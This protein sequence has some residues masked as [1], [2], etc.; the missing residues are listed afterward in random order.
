MK[1]D[2]RISRNIRA[3][4]FFNNINTTIHYC[5][6]T[7]LDESDNEL[8]VISVVTEEEDA[9]DEDLF[10]SECEE[11]QSF[12]FRLLPTT[13]LNFVAKR[14]RLVYVLDF[15][16]SSS[17]VD[18]KTGEVLSDKMYPCLHRCLSGLVK[19]FLLPGTNL[20][21]QTELYITVIAYTPVLACTVNQV[22]SQGYHL[23]EENLEGFLSVIKDKLRAFEL[24]LAS[25]TGSYNRNS[26]GSEN[27]HSIVT[28]DDE[29]QDSEET[30]PPSMCKANDSSNISEAGIINLLRQGLFAVQLLPENSSAGIVVISDGVLGVTDHTQ[31]DVIL[32]QLRSSTISCSF[33]KIGQSYCPRSQFG[34]V[35]HLELLQF[36]A[37]ATF[38]AYFDSCPDVTTNIESAH[39]NVYQKALLMW[40]FQKGLE[41][42]KYGLSRHRYLEP[43]HPANVSQRI[44]SHPIK[45]SLSMNTVIRRKHREM[46]LQTH[47]S[48]VLAVRLREGYTIK[49]ITF[50]KGNS[51]IEVQL[52]LPWREF[53][54]IEYSVKAE[55]PVDPNKRL[56]LVEIMLEGSY[57]F[58]H[59]MFS[60]ECSIKQRRWRS[61]RFNNVRKFHLTLQTLC[62]TDQLLVHLQSFDTNPV[63]HMLSDSI[64]NGLSVFY[65]TANSVTPMINTQHNTKDSMF[66]QFT[67]FWK[68]VVNLDIKIWQKWM[69]SH[70]IGVV[71][72]HDTPLPKYLHVPNASGRFS[73]VT[74]RQALTSLHGL[75]QKWS[76][77]V[78]I[79][80]SS[81]IKFL[82][83]DAEK[84]PSRFLLLRLTSKPPCMVIRA[85]FLGGTPGGMRHKTIKDLKRKV[86]ALKF[87]QRGAQKVDRT[88]KSPKD[89]AKDKKATP[90]PPLLR[91]WSEI[92]CCVL[93]TKP[94]EH[95][96]IS[97]ER[98]PRD[99]TV[100]EDPSKYIPAHMTSQQMNNKVT[101]ANAF[102]TLSRYLH[103]Q[104]WIWTVKQGKVD[105]TMQAV[106]RILSTLTKLNKITGGFHFASSN[107]GIV[108]MVLE[109]DMMHKTDGEK[110][111][112]VGDLSRCV[113]QYIM[114][115][116][117][118]KTTRE[119]TS[120][121]DLDEY[122]TT[123]ADGELQL[124][125]ECWIEPQYGVSTNN[126]PE[127]RQWNGLDYKGIARTFYPKDL[128]CLSS[129]V[130][131]DHL[132]YVCQNKIVFSDLPWKSDG[133]YVS[134]DIDS[135]SPYRD[136]VQ[137][138]S[139]FPANIHS[140]GFPFDLLSLLPKSQ[141][142]ELLFSSFALPEENS[143]DTYRDIKGSNSLLIELLHQKLMES[144]EREISL[145]HTECKV[146]L[147]LLKNRERDTFE[148]PFPFPM[149]HHI[150]ED[151][152]V[153]ESENQDE[154]DS[155]KQTTAAGVKSTS[156]A[157][158]SGVHGLSE[159]EEKVPLWKCFVRS[160]NNTHLYLTLLPASFDDLLLLRNVEL[161]SRRSESP[162]RRSESEPRDISAGKR[163]ETKSES[164]VKQEVAE[165]ESSTSDHADAA[166]KNADDQVMAVP[167][168]DEIDGNK[169][170]H[171]AGTESD[172]FCESSKDESNEVENPPSTTERSP[173]HV[174]PVYVYECYFNNIIDALVNP[175]GFKLPSDFHEDL[176][177][178][179][180]EN[181]DTYL[182]RSPM[183][184]RISFESERQTSFD[185][186]D[187]LSTPAHFM[188]LAQDRRMTE[189]SDGVGD[190]KQQ[191]TILTEAYYSCFVHG[192]FQS[193]QQGY[194]IDKHD[195][196]AAINNICTE[197]LPIETEITT[198]LHASCGHFQQMVESVRDT[199]Q[200]KEVTA[201]ETSPVESPRKLSVRFSDLID[202]EEEEG[203][204]YSVPSVLRLP[205][206]THSLKVDSMQPCEP[207]V[208]LQKLIKNK[209]MDIAQRWF[210]VVPSD[211][212]FYFYCP[213]SVPVR[214]RQEG[215]VDESTI[216]Q[217]P[218]FNF[219]EPK[220]EFPDKKSNNPDIASIASQLDSQESFNDSEYDLCEDLLQTKD[221]EMTPLFLHFTCTI[222]DRSENENVSITKLVPCLGELM[223]SIDRVLDLNLG[224]MKITFDIN[225]LTY[226]TDDEEDT[227]L[228]R[229][230]A[231]HRSISD[232][233]GVSDTSQG[234]L[235]PPQERDVD[236]S[237]DPGPLTK[238]MADP[239]AHLP[240]QQHDSVVKFKE[241][242]EWL[243]RDEIA[244]S[245]LHM[246]P[247][248]TD[249]LQ[250]VIE[251]IRQSSSRG[252]PTCSHEKIPL[253]FVYGAEHSL[254]KFNEEFERLHLHGYRLVQEENFYYCVR[255]KAHNNLSL[256]ACALNS[257]LVELS[258]EGTPALQGSLSL[259][260]LNQEDSLMS[261]EAGV[262]RTYV[263]P[264]F[265]SPE[266]AKFLR[267]SAV[268][269]SSDMSEGSTH[270]LFPKC[271]EEQ[272]PVAVDGKKP[273]ADQNVEGQGKTA[274]SRRSS[275]ESSGGSGRIVAVEF[276]QNLN[277]SKV[278]QTAVTSPGSNTN[279]EGNTSNQ[280]VKSHQVETT[281]LGDSLEELWLKKSSSFSGFQNDQSPE[282]IKRQESLAALPPLPPVRQT[283]Q[284][285]SLGRLRH[286]SA[287]S[288]QGTPRSKTST[289]PQ[290]P[291]WIS[292]R[293]SY[294]EEG[295]DGDSSESG[296]GTTAF[297]DVSGLQPSIPKFWLI[298]QINKDSV[299]I[300]YHC[301][302]TGQ[303]E[304]DVLLEQ[305]NLVTNVKKSIEGLCRKVNQTRVTSLEIPRHIILTESEEELEPEHQ[306]LAV[307]NKY[308][309][310]HFD[311]ECVMTHQ[312]LI[313]PRLKAGQGRAALQRGVQVLRT[314]LNCFSVNN[315]VNMF[316]IRE[317]ETQAVFYL[318]LKEFSAGSNLISRQ[319]SSISTE[320]LGLSD[321]ASSMMLH[322][323]REEQGLLS[324]EK[325][326]D[327]MSITSG[328]SI[329]QRVTQ[330]LVELHVHGIQPAGKE[331]QTDL[332][333]L[334]QN[335]LDDSI[336]DVISVQLMRNPNTKL[337]PEDVQATAMTH[338]HAVNYYL[339]Q[340]LLLFSHTP[341]Y[342]DTKPEHKFQDWVDNVWQAIPDDQVFLYITPRASAGKGIACIRAS[343][344]DGKGNPVRI[345]GCHKPSRTGFTYVQN[346]ADY[347]SLTHVESYLPGPKEKPGPTALI[348]FKIW[349]R[350]AAD[351]K[352]LQDKLMGAVQ[353][354][355]CDIITE[356][357]YLTASICD[358]PH[359]LQELLPAPVMSAPSSPIKV[360]ESSTERKPPSLSRK[361]SIDSKVFSSPSKLPDKLAS[362]SPL[363]SFKE[364]FS[365]K[366]RITS[367]PPD[368]NKTFDI[369][370]SAAI[371]SVASPIGSTSPSTSVGQRGSDIQ[372]VVRSYEEGDRGSLHPIYRE[373]IVKWLNHCTQHGSPSMNVS[374]FSLSSTHSK[375]YFLREFQTCVKNV[376]SD[377]NPRVFKMTYDG[378]GNCHH[379]TQYMP[380]RHQLQ[381]L[382]HK[383]ETSLDFESKMHSKENCSFIMIGRNVDQWLAS[384]Q[385]MNEEEMAEVSLIQS[386]KTKA[387]PKQSFQKFPP[388]LSEGTSVKDFIE[389]EIVKETI[390]IPRQR[391]LFLTLHKLEIT[392]FTYNWAGDAST[393]L[394]KAVERLVNWN[395]ARKSLMDSILVQ[396]MGLFYHLPFLP[397][398]TDKKKK[399]PYTLHTTDIDYLI[400]HTA[401]PVEQAKR[402]SSMSLIS[403]HL[404]S[405]DQ[406]LKDT[407]PTRPLQKSRFIKY[408]DPVKKHCGQ[409]QELRMIDKKDSEKMNKLNKLWFWSNKSSINIPISD[410]VIQTLKQSSRLFHYCA[411]PLLFD[412]HWRLK[413]MEK[414]RVTQRQTST[415]KQRSRHSSGTSIASLRTKRADSQEG[416]KRPCLTPADSPIND[417]RQ[418]AK[419]EEPWH[420]DLRTSFVKQYIEYVQSLGFVLVQTRPGTPKKGTHVKKSSQDK[421]HVI[422]EEGVH[423][424][425]GTTVLHKFLSAGIMLMEL[426][427]SEQYF[428]AKVYVCE[429]TRLG[430]YVNKQLQNLFVDESI[431]CKELIH[432]HS[433]AHDFHLRCIQSYIQAHILG[434]HTALKPS[435]N[436]TGFLMDF[437]KVYNYPP[438][439][440]RN[441]L[442]EDTILISDLSSSGTQLFEYII[443]HQKIHGLKVI[444][445][446]PTEMD[447]DNDFCLIPRGT[448]YALIQQK[449]VSTKDL[450][451]RSTDK[452]EEYHVCLVITQDS[453]QL[454]FQIEAEKNSL[455]LNYFLILTSKI[456]LFPTADRKGEEFKDMVLQELSQRSKPVKQHIGARKQQQVSP[457]IL[458]TPAGLLLMQEAEIA[459]KRMFEI[460][461]VSTAKCRK[462]LLWQRMLIGDQT[463]EDA[464]RKPRSETE[465]SR[466]GIQ[467]LSFEEFL[468]LLEMTT[469][470][471]L[472]D[473]DKQLVSL[474]NMSLPWYKGLYKKLQTKYPE[475]HRCFTSSDGNVQ[476]ILILNPNWLDMLMMLKIDSRSNKVE[477][478]SVFKEPLSDQGETLDG[479][480]SL[481]SSSYHALV[482]DFVNVCCFYL[483]ST[484]LCP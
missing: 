284:L 70:K 139:L 263:S 234:N 13:V 135:L 474:H 312:F 30:T 151:V 463:E 426:S 385:D 131:F 464:K 123:E 163:L 16:P 466:D 348:Q 412:P 353:Y 414:Y 314:V 90:K 238:S 337:P 159:S 129:L 167:G 166:A 471:S 256:N 410:E 371:P 443:Q 130:T 235:S 29:R 444:A 201:E 206:G 94:V 93:L 88:K 436:L 396:K 306:Y 292:S 187:D 140:M 32:N 219:I 476:C 286:S 111:E 313:H 335:K 304:S 346:T 325:D 437:H 63:H 362:P 57:D 36:I 392:L 7:C 265:I 457:N 338:L 442:V 382:E 66:S 239:I 399:N 45:Q 200:T 253:H 308:L 300:Y 459:R 252:K 358:I 101:V 79:D 74:C 366:S 479:S 254:K 405:I 220:T 137:R 222:K 289:I 97:Y 446:T 192:V 282:S 8:T 87:P 467:R 168:M 352:S 324:T 359:Q 315:R 156:H 357:N 133:S 273:S 142:A 341:N 395:N 293:G 223:S 390:F 451:T 69:H 461:E 458:K 43:S 283:P 42:F 157:D 231:Y 158:V 217:E 381:T 4:W 160:V 72:E 208:E 386:Q 418:R 47:M 64:K 475:M 299:D 54:K 403:P 25:N 14:Y 86:L 477:M 184:K 330:D 178:A 117:H 277:R 268:A 361:N 334:L 260:N 50:T 1:K 242:L 226:P 107:S 102:N 406:T 12:K 247:V 316:V 172:T 26:G 302:E 202:E 196:S 274:S 270:Y 2:Y 38:G 230:P 81:Y 237:T 416:K 58:L 171:I 11:N 355:L 322:A 320:D 215:A 225:C 397:D 147:G 478:C 267:Q 378:E 449:E 95:I 387:F 199:I 55:W 169:P 179:V 232:G 198:F 127:R 195:V 189:C 460:V 264:A 453:Q 236:I 207:L 227:T 393:T 288:G 76:T 351:T 145:T 339:R 363:Q 98:K 245:L 91:E 291:S 175:W 450:C 262:L 343:L 106:G 124:V 144:S 389:T 373:E 104:R 165:I 401:P 188:R 323:R 329:S 309:P 480:V 148:N 469:K 331:I 59:D 180:G 456:E 328:G 229:R 34:Y 470:T 77:F 121:D 297:S 78:L 374:K 349:E 445:M 261:S 164:N 409:A 92:S 27:D 303:I 110:S 100:L 370:A 128:E 24:S 431:K 259:N 384:V 149:E 170:V 46:K 404:R 377:V 203:T 109:V 44:F 138:K 441:I 420:F 141:Q 423:I 354:T 153:V 257:A 84:S 146:F 17:L 37:T 186:R 248:K 216:F 417:P 113:V 115:P 398:K 18:L 279:Q 99:M 481:S 305:R 413:V 120:E 22:L 5:P 295:Y 241:E 190:L 429:S 52:V 255:T 174:I 114:F 204:T 372:Q 484:M 10:S 122:E 118:I 344:V 402:H 210:K 244:S 340:N 296:D 438:K 365:V 462:D 209:F 155:N 317:H 271:A 243:L 197:S 75:L 19:P 61:I 327:T 439:F 281:C 62:Q 383:A 435:Y 134:S 433:F 132:L 21:F 422:D 455:R 342:S 432:V 356:Y 345:F 213:E 452:V 473:I 60:N 336:L 173:S 290:T 482:E 294:T 193:L 49:N 307:E 35:P 447:A 266:C 424:P 360:K 56:T 376:S 276:E 246:Q 20:L 272:S 375:D 161:P 391:L 454:N 287:P 31:F 3:S 152:T 415:E 269:T 368:T 301:R 96:L 321:S 278:E 425:S 136:A 33:L 181:D 116:P 143:E 369:P 258:R 73:I 15:S 28:S 176:T 326:F 9:S 408:S 249:A 80:G 468:E 105:I 182:L 434:S 67:T 71:L 103:H 298:L 48:S 177:F 126:S 332:V 347:Q 162:A 23:T 380:C 228:S 185:E 379:V 367:P 40:S 318:R 400:M 285:P 53:A 6:K 112:S 205:N 483:W 364:A 214:E 311:C 472:S 421:I 211:P 108:N 251:H 407:Q 430:V 221:N 150:K 240:K 85:A 41:G 154:L 250:F 440:S 319:V 428:C 65:Q 448:E 212:N 83:G 51:Q 427:F 191:C 394:V 82:D 218:E 224:Q 39:M 350:G 275:K 333:Q 68:P 233:S 465:E 419:R 183:F 125:T 119:S 388:F 89:E 194:Y 280:A 411:T 310:G